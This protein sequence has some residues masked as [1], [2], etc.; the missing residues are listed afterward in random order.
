[1]AKND[2]FRKDWLDIVFEHRNKAYGAYN[3][4]KNSSRTTVLSLVAGMFL[5]SAVFIVPTVISNL[6]ASNDPGR[7]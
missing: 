1:M 7:L 4:R 2:L 5:F 3:L 6:F